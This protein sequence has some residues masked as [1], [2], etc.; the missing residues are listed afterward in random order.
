MADE[1]T[2]H[3]APTRRDYMKYGGAVIGGG[4]LAGCAGQSDSGSTPTEN[5]TT[6]ATEMETETTTDD[7]SYTVEMFPVGEV[8]FEEVPETWMATYR[9]AYTDMAVA[10]GQVDG[11]RSTTIGRFQM[12]YDLLG[13]E[14]ESDHKDTMQDGSLSKEVFYELDCD[15]HLMDP[16]DVASNDGWD[17]SDVEEIAENVGPFFGCYHRRFW[18]GGYHE[19]HD[20][21]AN[22][23]TMLEAFEK[24]GA[25]FQEP[26]RAQAFLDLHEEMQEEIDSRTEDL[27]T[28][29]IGLIN[30]GSDPAKG[31]FYAM[32]PS[33]QGYEMKHY[34][35]IG[36]K[37]GFEGVETGQYGLID[38]ETL[39]EVDPEYIVVH[40]QIATENEQWDPDLFEEKFIEPM[41]ND[42]TGQELTAVKEENIVPGAWAEQGPIINLFST[43]VAGQTLYPEQFGEFPWEQYPEVPEENQLFDRQRVRDIVNGNF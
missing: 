18:N 24:V 3:E 30:G 2:E 40:W 13:I 27:D 39:L 23:P 22:A 12:W 25:V 29:E 7:G 42:P 11:N 14:Y 26:E 19:E 21:P 6:A 38:Y 33:N 32:D 37:N 35:D 43:E 15:V 4:L 1:A 17:E 5:T 8:E 28:V 20:Y 34:R 41:A 9:D 10:L 16:N 31:E 36:V